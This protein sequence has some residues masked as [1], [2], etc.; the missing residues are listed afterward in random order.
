[1]N[2]FLR[3]KINIFCF[4]NLIVW[5]MWIHL[6]SLLRFLISPGTTF[7]PLEMDPE[8]VTLEANSLFLSFSLS[9]ALSRCF[10]TTVPPIFLPQ[11]EESSSLLCLPVKSCPQQENTHHHWKQ[12]W[13]FTLGYSL[14]LIK[15]FIFFQFIVKKHGAV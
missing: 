11:N 10:Q 1:M 3:G 13:V 6:D 8:Q 4:P 14:P 9:S 5:D 7:S 15:E 2:S 12:L